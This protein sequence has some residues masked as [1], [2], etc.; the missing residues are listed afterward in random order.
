MLKYSIG[1]DGTAYT[2]PDIFSWA[3]FQKIYGQ[4]DDLNVDTK[5]AI[6]GKN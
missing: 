1:D 5:D 4:E 3:L 2:D 6:K